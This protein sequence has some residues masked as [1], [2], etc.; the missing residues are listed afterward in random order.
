MLVLKVRFSDGSCEN[1]DEGR[2]LERHVII[3][4]VLRSTI[5]RW[6]YVYTYM[7][8]RKKDTYKENER[9]RLKEIETVYMCYHC[10]INKRQ[11]QYF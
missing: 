1:K 10:C 2:I 11:K 6:E 8:E 9:E 4:N 3:H 5:K 7:R